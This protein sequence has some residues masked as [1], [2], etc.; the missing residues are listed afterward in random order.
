MFDLNYNEVTL[1]KLVEV[2]ASGKLIYASDGSVTDTRASF[3]WVVAN[4]STKKILCFCSGPVFGYQ[5][6]SYQS[7]IYDILSPQIFPLMMIQHYSLSMRFM[8]I[9]LFDNESLVD[10]YND[11]NI[12]LE[13]LLLNPMELND[14]TTI[15]IHSFNS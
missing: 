9:W 7:E 6:C 1:L 8:K 15:N 10:I 2:N 5:I 12:L 11:N 4:K 3:G 14:K 13:N